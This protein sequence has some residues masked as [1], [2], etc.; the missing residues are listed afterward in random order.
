[1]PTDET[2]IQQTSR[3]LREGNE[4][5]AKQE[6]LIVRLEQDGHDSLLPQAR[7]LLAQL[8]GL[9]RAGQEH[10]DREVAKAADASP[11][12]L[13]WARRSAAGLAGARARTRGV[14]RAGDLAEIEQHL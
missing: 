9:Q 11:A 10:L 2:P 1:M 12:S 6:A 8:H 14:D 5:I 7:E 4:R 3:H 13:A